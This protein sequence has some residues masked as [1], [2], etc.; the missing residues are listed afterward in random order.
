M[1]KI[2][3]LR[4]VLA[5]RSLT[6]WCRDWPPVLFLHETMVSIWQDRLPIN[7][8]A[9]QKHASQGIAARMLAGYAWKWTSE[10][11]GNADGAV[12]DVT[13]PGFNFRMPWN[14]RRSRTTWAIDPAG[15]EQIGCIHTSQGLEFDYVGV[16]IGLDLRF[17]KDNGGFRASWPDYKDSAGKKGLKQD[18]ESLSLL[19]RNIYKTLMSRAM[20]GCYVF[21]CDPGLATYLRESSVRALSGNPKI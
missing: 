12:D 1:A 9:I 17:E 8:A 11:D 3:I 16:I 14:S 10:K 2:S 15:A 4:R 6:A 19:I 21:A 18:P 20:K 5:T 13:I 7:T